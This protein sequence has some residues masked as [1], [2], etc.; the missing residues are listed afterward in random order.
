MSEYR[1]ENH[2]YHESYERSWLSRL[3][4]AV[5]GV[6]VGLILYIAAFPLLVWNESRT[7]ARYE[8]LEEGAKAVLSLPE[9]KVDPIFENK[10]VHLS[11]QAKSEETLQDVEFGLSTHAI[12]LRRHVEMFQ[13]EEKQEEHSEK[14]L[15]G[16]ERVETR[17]SYQKT[18]L[19]QLINSSHFNQAQYQ[20]PR[21][22]PFSDLTQ[23]A[24]T[25]SLGEFKL[26]PTLIEKINAFRPLAISNLIPK[27]LLTTN[28][29]QLSNE[30]VFVGM[31]PGSPKVGDVRVRFDYVAPEQSIS[32]V[33]QQKSNTLGAY[34][35]KSG[36]TIA[37]LAY[38]SQSPQEM[39]ANANDENTLI[40]WGIRAGGLI[41]MI[42]GIG[43]LLKPIVV[44]ADIV[45]LFGSIV[46]FGT[47]LIAVVIGLI[48][49]LFTIAIAWF[50]V[51]PLLSLAMAIT[52][53]FLLVGMAWVRRKT[54]PTMVQ[55]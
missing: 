7:L 33:G 13:W 6:V 28:D 55:T 2:T 54:K 21:S 30:R 50:A 31:D 18:W 1:N 17:Y 23:R 52:G 48:S 15:G 3:K 19:G 5:L 42:L 20:N 9:A 49:A 46:N 43:L 35:T 32:V 34:R 22:M 14:Q 53:L 26:S 44:F 4:D 47:S 51:R 38:G 11:G 25:V 45:P 8:A 37:L 39:F 40:A 29:W 27:Q 10:L 41:A 16:S 12:Q 36:G 24:D